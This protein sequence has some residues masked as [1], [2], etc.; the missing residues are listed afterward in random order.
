MQVVIRVPWKRPKN[1][2]ADLNSHPKSDLETSSTLW[3]PE[4]DAELWKLLALSPPD[5]VDWD[6]VAQKL[7]ITPEECSDR[8]TF[9]Y[10]QQIEKIQQH[11]FQKKRQSLLMN[12]STTSVNNNSLMEYPVNSNKSLTNIDVKATTTS[13]SDSFRDPSSK[14][15]RHLPNIPRE[16]LN[17]LV[18]KF[19]FDWVKVGAELNLD[20]ETCRE[21]FNYYERQ[22]VKSQRRNASKLNA[23]GSTS[24]PRALYLDPNHLLNSMKAGYSPGPS[25]PITPHLKALETIPAFVLTDSTGSLADPSKVNRTTAKGENESNNSSNSGSFLSNDSISKSALESAYLHMEHSEDS[26]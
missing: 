10:R 21:V 12:Q 4:R 15:T 6:S 14:L 20:P 18:T 16:V 19:D 7:N 23:A 24:N 26:D 25:R 11:M 5:Q 13:G 9:L 8:S 17:P 22:D 2:V 3:T 1:F